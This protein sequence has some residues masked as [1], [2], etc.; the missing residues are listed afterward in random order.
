[1]PRQNRGVCRHCICK[2]NARLYHR[3]PRPPRLQETFTRAG[4]GQNVA[5]LSPKDA[6][7]LN[8]SRNA[9]HACSPRAQHFGG[10]RQRRFPRGQPCARGRPPAANL[11]ISVLEAVSGFCRGYAPA[12]TAAGEAPCWVA[13]NGL[14]PVRPGLV[15][16]LHAPATARESVFVITRLPG[17]RP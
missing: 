5:P 17:K 14:P 9:E 2:A 4:W 1:L 12:K 7:K 6:Y 13:Q 3:R 11:A 10:N 16:I 15:T 8:A